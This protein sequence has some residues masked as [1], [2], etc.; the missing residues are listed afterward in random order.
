M[1]FALIPYGLDRLL[2]FYKNALN[3][4]RTKVR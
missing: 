2:I 3:V 4:I 1:M